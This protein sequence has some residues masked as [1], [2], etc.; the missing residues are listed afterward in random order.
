MPNKFVFMWADV[1]L[2]RWGGGSAINSE[3]TGLEYVFYNFVVQV[4]FRG[5]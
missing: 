4:K 1:E 5:R 3:G 2:R